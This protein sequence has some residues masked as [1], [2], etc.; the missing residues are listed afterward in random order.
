M[1]LPVYVLGLLPAL[2]GVGH[3]KA[4]CWEAK[5]GSEHNLEDAQG[6]F[7]LS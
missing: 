5:V 4:M 7:P 6:S 2:V 1:H 3:L